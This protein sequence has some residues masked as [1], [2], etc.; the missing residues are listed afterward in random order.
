MSGQVHASQF[1]GAVCAR[2]FHMMDATEPLTIH[3]TVFRRARLPLTGSEGLRMR[4]GATLLAVFFSACAGS[5]VGPCQFSTECG[6]GQLCIDGACVASGE[7]N[8]DATP[9]VVDSADA[10]DAG[11]SEPPIPMEPS[12]VCGNGLDDDRNG[13]VDDGCPCTLGDTQQCYP[14]AEGPPQGCTHGVQRCVDDGEFGAWSSCEGAIS[15]LDGAAVCCSDPGEPLPDYEGC[16]QFIQVF[17]EDGVWTKPMAGT[18]L[19]V[20]C[21]GAG[22][23]GGYGDSRNP[24]HSA[25]GGGGGGFVTLAR[26]LA[27]MPE[28][29]N[30]TVGT[31]GPGADAD[32]AL[33]NGEAGGDTMFGMFA[34]AGGGQG[35]TGH[36]GPGGEGG[37]GETNN[38]EPGG[39]GVPGSNSDGGV[40]GRAGGNGGAGGAGGVNG[41]EH[42]TAG[43]FPGGGGGGGAARGRSLN[44]ASGAGG[45]CIAIV[46]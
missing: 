44:G 43:T 42:G 6:L 34:T 19:T 40:G 8:G 4:A 1:P 22:G 28:T 25:G 9:M 23:G 46:T 30:V 20:R 31:G 38:G 21:W 14:G 5:S 15:P 29:V 12:D 16:G 10:G 26:S 18:D 2:S 32:N 37:V 11:T 7:V 17:R 3:L 24:D 35:G 45:Y 36:G 39:P 27:E 13:E 41:V 33:R